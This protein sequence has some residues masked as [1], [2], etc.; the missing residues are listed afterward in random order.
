M[1]GGRASA[2]PKLAPTVSP[3]KT[4]SGALAG[5]V[6]G[7]RWWRRCSLR[8]SF[9]ASGVEAPLWQLLAIAGGAL[10]DRP[11]RRPRGIP[12]QARGGVKDSSHLIPGH[13]GVLDRF[14][15]LYFVLPA[16]AAMY[17]A[18]RSHLMSGSGRQR[19][20]AVLGSTGSIGRSTLEVLRRQREHFRRR[21]P[22]RRPQPR[23]VRGAGGR[24]AARLRRAGG[25]RQR[26]ALAQRSRG[27]GRGGDSSRRGHRGQRGG[28][29]GRARR[30][31]GGAPGRQAGRAGQQGDA[32]DGGRP[33]GPGGVRRRG[34]DRPGGLGAQRGA[35]VRHRPRRRSW[36]A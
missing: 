29:R 32:G 9:R 1:F 19:G 7:A 17:R 23:R 28:R 13:G 30:H 26:R 25:A 5:V 36:A 34:R 8:W 15:S 21:G 33:G 16:A 27:A 3:G 31:A 35:P 10:G 6:G 12:L 2:A 24:M 4:R 20:V 14:D 18:V 11:D 22:D